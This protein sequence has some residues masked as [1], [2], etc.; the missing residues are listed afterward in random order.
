MTN[1]S[2]FYQLLDEERGV[3]KSLSE[4]TGIS[5][6]NISDWKSGRSK[7][8]ADKL[9]LIADYFHCS[10]DYLL[11]RTP[12]KQ[13]NYPNNKV[14][15][16]PVMEQKASA[17]LGT[18]TNDISDI[19]AEFICFKSDHIPI[20]ATHGIIIDG[21][22]MEDR[23]FDNQLVFIERGRECNTDEYGIFVAQKRNGLREVYCKQKRQTNSGI[24]YLHS[25][26]RDYPD[27]Y[28]GKDNI[29]NF[30]CIGKVL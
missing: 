5:T 18:I 14:I 15:Y 16:L 11:G 12:I 24:Y 22:S 7:P 29:V 21:H 6:G 19:E 9:I 25:V 20:G 28:V 10:I 13:V 17:G 30:W 3:A 2:R 23:F 1:L 8:S 26:N 4:A 27:I